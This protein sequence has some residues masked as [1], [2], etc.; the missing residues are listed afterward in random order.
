M[1]S[2]VLIWAVLAV[3]IVVVIVTAMHMSA[4]R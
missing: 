3:T 4:G 2:V 1:D